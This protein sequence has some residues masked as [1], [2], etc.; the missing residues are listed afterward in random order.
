MRYSILI[1]FVSR[2]SLQ[3]VEMINYDMAVY[4]L[5][6]ALTFTSGRQVYVLVNEA[7]TGATFNTFFAIPHFL[8]PEDLSSILIHLLFNCGVHV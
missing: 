2:L 1:S 3:R 4:S 6:I 7:A 5:Y 8:E